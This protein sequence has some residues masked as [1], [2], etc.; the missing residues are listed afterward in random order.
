MSARQTSAYLTSQARWRDNL[1]AGLGWRGVESFC[2]AD[3]E[4]RGMAR[5]ARSEATRRKIIDAALELYDEL[6]YAATGMGDIIE[7]AKITKGAL[8]YHFDS[9]ES[10]AAEIIT[11]GGERTVAAFCDACESSAPAIE[12][13]IHS[14]F[15]LADRLAR[16][17]LARAATQ[18]MPTLAPRL[19]AARLANRK[20]MAAVAA[21]LKRVGDEGDLRTDLDPDAAAETLV[22]ASSGTMLM[23][24]ETSGGAD[25]AE[26]MLRMWD[27]LLPAIVPEES[28][29]YLRQF[30]FRAPL[31]QP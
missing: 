2:S 4:V 8:Y 23:S 30:L 15:L 12:N 11:M 14:T 18:L 21:Q 25:L 6:G 16:D 24:L 22:A 3:R 29:S 5:Q 27:V 9:K 13:L 31:R 26:R 28:L 19:E 20:W 1:D 17:K 7:R 10:V